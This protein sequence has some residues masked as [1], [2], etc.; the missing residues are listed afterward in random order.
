MILGV[1]SPVLHKYAPPPVAVNTVDSPSQKSS[2][3]TLATG[4]GCSVTVMEATSVQPNPVVT[5]TVNVPLSETVMDA[6][7]APVLHK[8]VPPP[9][10]VRT[11]DSPSQKSVS[12]VMLATGSACSVTV[13][14]AISVQP[15]P[16]VTTT[17]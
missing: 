4:F 1:V 13:M 12:P 2:P 5:S 11:V 10:A 8:Y 3:V 7:V 9:V 14:E 16:L 6:V 17:E 15:N